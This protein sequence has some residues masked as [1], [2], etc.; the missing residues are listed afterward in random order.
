MTRETASPQAA[1]D[2]ASELYSQQANKL[3][4]LIEDIAKA[5]PD[6]VHEKLESLKQGVASLCERSKDKAGNL[7][8]KVT[9]TVKA[10][11]LETAAAAVGAGLLTWWLLSRR[12]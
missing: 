11:P 1:K 10:H 12:R 6:I 4:D 9:D 2:L 5:A 3:C 7:V 8:C